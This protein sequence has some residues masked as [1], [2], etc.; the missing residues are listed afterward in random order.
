MATSTVDLTVSGNSG[1]IG[2]GLFMTGQLQP[3]GT[4]VFDS[5]VPLQQNGSEQGYNTNAAPQ[6]N[7]GSSLQHN[8]SILLADVP[9]V[10]GDGSNGT[11]EGAAYREFLLDLNDAGG[12]RGLLS[13][14]KLQIWQE[15]SGSLTNFTPGAGFSGSHT[16]YLAYDLDTGGDHWIALDTGLAHGSGQSDVR[17]LIRNDLFINDT[18]HRYVTLYSAFGQQGGTWGSDG[19]F[20]EWGLHGP[21]GGAKSALALVKSAAVDG[22]HRGSSRRG[23]RLQLH[24]LK[25]RQH[26]ADRRHTH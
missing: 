17:V 26:S 10:F 3:A 6:F 2:D 12:T 14:D 4:G 8:H 13:L 5:F 19:G 24:T 21:S 23:H 1:A 22:R 9:I 7:E 11:I 16:N 15:E 20:E 18:A 25:H